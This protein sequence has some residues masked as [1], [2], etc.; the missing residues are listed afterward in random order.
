MKRAH[1]AAIAAS[2]LLPVLL[3][4]CGSDSSTSSSSPAA[5]AEASSEAASAPASSAPASSEAASDPASSAPAGELD[6]DAALAEVE[7][8]ISAGG[9]SA[10]ATSCIVDWA[11]TLDDVDLAAAAAPPGST[12]T[13]EQQAAQAEI[14]VTCARQETIDQFIA[15]FADTDASEAAQ[16]C[17]ADY[18][19][20]LP[21]EELGS[22]L[23]GE[24]AAQQ[25]LSAAAQAC[26][27][28]E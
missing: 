24:E 10:E 2:T 27:A 5:S 11:G 17:L 19:N 7:R 18:M 9:F 22:L 28:A 1:L 21:D 14:L 13:A 8:Q 20:I 4:G 6:R 15:G 16:A 12:P 25:S 26:A 3:V 23:R